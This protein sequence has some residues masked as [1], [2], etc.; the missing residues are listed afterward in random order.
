[1]NL[2]GAERLRFLKRVATIHAKASELFELAEEVFGQDDDAS[3]PYFGDLM[4]SAA[5]LRNRIEAS[6]AKEDARHG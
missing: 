3:L 6:A 1:M 2:T 5:E 4:C